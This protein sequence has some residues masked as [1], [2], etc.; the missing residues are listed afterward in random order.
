MKAMIRDRYGSPA[1]VRLEEAGKPVPGD[2]EVLVRVRGASVNPLDWHFLRGTP[3]LLR[4][5]LGLPRPRK[6][7]LGADLA[8]EVEALGPNVKALHAGD[9]VFGLSRGTFAEFVCARE[10]SLAVKPV[11]CSFPE[12][13]A[14]PIAGCT[15]LQGLRDHARAARGQGV[16]INGAAGGVGTFAVQIARALGLEVTGVCSTRN[17]DLVRALGATTVIDYTRDDFAAGGRRYDVV[18]DC[19][20]NRPL[21]ALRRV[22]APEGACV[23]IGGG[24]SSA[25]IVAGMLGTFVLSR[26]V[27][28]KLV[29]FLASVNTADL[30]VLRELIDSGQVRVVVDRE[31]P[32]ERVAEA[33]AY[34]E[35]GHARG[36]VTIGVAS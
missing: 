28:Q 30:G 16:L 25:A 5:G 19:V 18:F 34:L 36:K 31:Y 20:G 2:G 12:A 32:L 1:V 9:A 15:A 35:E 10:T 22:L 13:A 33:L 11:S 26:V 29:S 24:G 27:R 14:I 17:V 7:G 23:M 8:G 4:V 6:P 3:R 21:S